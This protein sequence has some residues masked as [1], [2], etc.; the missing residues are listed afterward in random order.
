MQNCRKLCWHSEDLLLAYQLT[1]FTKRPQRELASHPKFYLFNDYSNKKSRIFM[2]S[3]VVVNHLKDFDFHFEGVEVVTA[4]DYLSED[5]YAE[6]KHARIY[7][8]CKSY[9]YQS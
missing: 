6:L 8:L 4:K 1:V 3:I 5:Y 2:H 7:N 9:K